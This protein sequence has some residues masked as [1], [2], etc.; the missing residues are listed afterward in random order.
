MLSGVK[1]L[2]QNKTK[3]ISI[4]KWNK[5][6]LHILWASQVVLLVKNQPASAGDVGDLGLILGQ[7]DPLKEGMA[8]NCSILAWRI[9]W[10]EDHGGLHSIGLQS[11]GHDWVDLACTHIQQTTKRLCSVRLCTLTS[12]DLTCSLLT[13]HTLCSPCSTLHPCLPS[14]C[15][16]TSSSTSQHSKGPAGVHVPLSCF[17]C[18]RPDGITVPSRP[19]H[20]ALHFVSRCPACCP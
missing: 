10:R 4:H 11:V 14:P 5:T 16:P 20:W 12:R 17:H 2:F 7:E 19:C 18:G 6:E 1:D 8:T 13:C 3:S 9:P 15:A